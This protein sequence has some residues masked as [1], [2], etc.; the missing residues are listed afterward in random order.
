MPSFLWAALAV[1]C[2]SIIVIIMSDIIYRYK[3]KQQIS[4]LWKLQK[5]LETFIRPYHRYAYYFETY[6]TSQLQDRI[7]DDKT[8]FDLDLPK[9]FKRM[10]F[11][12]TAIGEMRLY[13]TLR[14][15]TTVDNESLIQLFKSN[16]Y[17]RETVSYHLALIGKSIYPIYP[18][19]LAPV[20][21]QTVFM[22][23]TYLPFVGLL[24]FFIDFKIG[25]IVTL[26]FIVLN[27]VLSGSLRKT[28][29]QNLNS[30]YYT[31][32]V[33]Q[34][35]YK[36]HKLEGLPPLD[37]NFKHFTASR[38]LSWLLGRANSNNDAFSIMLL[39]KLAFMVDYHIFHLIQHSY[40]RYEAEVLACYD[41]IATLDNHYSVALWRETLD[42]YATPEIT[43]NFMI[44][45]KDVTH[46]LLTNAVPNTLTI[47]FQMLLAGSN[48]SG[49][50]TYM[51][52]I[53]LN[54]ILAQTVQT[55]TANKF[56]YK[57][58]SVFTS[59]ANQD[60]VI[61]GESYFMTEL[62]AIRRLFNGQNDNYRYYFIDEIFK[63]TN[64]SERIAASESVLRYL[65]QQPN[66]RIMAATHD[67]ELASLLQPD[68]KNYHFNETISDN[69]I[70]FDF[71]IKSGKANTRN[72]IEL[73][74]ITDF[75]T[76]I[77]E[78]AKNNVEQR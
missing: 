44:E 33:I 40:K 45:S 29:E 31:A 48:A 9:L 39:F 12:F 61:S 36:L 11:N 74:R 32:S 16:S 7:I 38:K 69:E 35:A 2:F 24:L 5:Y 26:M 14:N 60:D 67:I 20:K 54:L 52:A 47:D 59:M 8:W 27:F 3:L 65:N 34:K 19:Q 75:P 78:R 30:M 25:T 55:V 71:I 10:N 46:P 68:Y 17:I 62:K 57:P 37:V 63:G 49:K 6:Q 51:K 73:L 50:S 1:V 23:C 4:L 64:T 53:A 70:H 18:D 22:Y 13:S 15:M 76:P 77:Y 21:H 42:Y 41:Y 28:F 58:G 43:D 72:A 66:T 56:K